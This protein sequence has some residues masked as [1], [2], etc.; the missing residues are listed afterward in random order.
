MIV[1]EE[2]WARQWTSLKG[3]TWEEVLDACVGPLPQGYSEARRAFAEALSQ[4]PS[5]QGD[6]LSTIEQMREAPLL[7]ETDVDFCFS[8][9]PSN[10]KNHFLKRLL[11]LYLQ[12][13]L[14]ESDR[15]ARTQ[16][17]ELDRAPATY[18]L[19][20]APS[21]SLVK[22]RKSSAAFLDFCQRV[23]RAREHGST[24]IVE[25]WAL[26]IL[27]SPSTT[28]FST[29]FFEA[30]QA[31]SAID[32]LVDKLVQ[33][34]ARGFQPRVFFE[35]TDQ[36]KAYL[37]C[38]A[39]AHGLA[40][41]DT[42]GPLSGAARSFE[43]DTPLTAREI[44][45]LSF[46]PLPAQ[47]KCFDLFFLEPLP[48]P[49]SFL[50]LDGSER[51]RLRNAGFTLAEAEPHLER[52]QERLH[53]LQ[54]NGPGHRMVFYT[55]G[56]ALPVETRTF[57][58]PTH[59]HS[60]AAR[61]K[62]SSALPLEPKGLSASALENYAECPAKFLFQNSLRL[63]S[64]IETTDAFSL[65]FGQLTHRALEWAFKENAWQAVDEPL[66]TQ[67]FDKALVEAS[68]EIALE[69]LKTSLRRRFREVAK[70]V[71]EMERT[72]RN[73]FGPLT[74]FRYEDDFEIALGNTVLRGRVDRI[75]Q[76][77]NGSLLVLD[78][79]TG[80][81]DFSPEH[82]KKGSHFQ[83]LVY[84]LAKRDT[85]AGVLFYD[86]KAGEVKR[87][88]VKHSEVLSEGKKAFVR[89]HCLTLESWD[90]V[91]DEGLA[92][93]QRLASAIAAGQFD[94]RPSPSA[95][96]YCEVGSLCRSRSGVSSA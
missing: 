85:I 10:E 23:A 2:A 89:G 82:I 78:Y 46:H 54:E 72:L 20:D 11:L 87:G 17:L 61:P 36:S 96:E 50:T 80:K 94:P 76:L 32:T 6:W 24:H 52:N 45:I 49:T 41:Y 79:K 66:L 25:T 53:A 3:V 55:P 64:P 73:L 58:S 14:A 48:E 84:A 70:S 40:L 92:H 22:A 59:S 63:R 67:Y 71:A 28:N 60:L 1:F 74:P 26:T 51:F 43:N 75:D 8:H 90:S 81:V 77:S 62:A 37:L 56:F 29:V 5:E 21:V 34:R 19:I 93:I 42:I 44:P 4:S 12:S 57:T 31:A 33:A 65:Y 35:G 69:W 30:S 38:S 27:P 86:L 47:P 68:P 88:L 7:G 9:L 16:R 83:A 18:S 13:P 39:A 15:V 95:C 91:I